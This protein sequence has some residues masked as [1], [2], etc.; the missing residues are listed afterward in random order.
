MRLFRIFLISILFPGS[1]LFA[2]W[3]IDVEHE[4]IFRIVVD[5]NVITIFS[6]DYDANF[7]VLLSDHAAIHP[8]G[9]G[10]HVVFANRVTPMVLDRF[11]TALGF[12]D[13]ERLSVW[14]SFVQAHTELLTLPSVAALA[15]LIAAYLNIELD[16]YRF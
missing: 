3:S 9:Y 14:E 5:R 13:I 4:S 8:C 1:P 10:A 11:L 16:E 6:F 12:S 2:D 7:D 15:N